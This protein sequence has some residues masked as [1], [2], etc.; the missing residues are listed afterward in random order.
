MVQIRTF[1]TKEKKLPILICCNKMVESL[2]L[3]G[4]AVTVE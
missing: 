4:L 3:C 2:N 1:S